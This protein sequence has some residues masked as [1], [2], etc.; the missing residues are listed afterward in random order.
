[1]PAARPI[2][3]R[4]GPVVYETDIENP[5]ALV[6]KFPKTV[7]IAGIN[8]P[9]PNDAADRGQRDQPAEVADEFSSP[10]R[11]RILAVGG[12]RGASPEPTRR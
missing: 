12:A 3:P 2:L 5:N 4:P 9:G 1:V 7:L 11:G 6:K 8:G 10:S